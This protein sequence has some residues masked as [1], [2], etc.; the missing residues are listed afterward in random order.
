APPLLIINIKHNMLTKK[1]GHL[2]IDFLKQ[3]QQNN[4]ENVNIDLNLITAFLNT[5]SYEKIGYLHDFQFSP[6]CWETPERIFS[7]V[8]PDAITPAK[9]MSAIELSQWEQ[10]SDFA[11]IAQLTRSDNLY[12]QL[13]MLMLI[14]Q[15]YDLDFDLG[16]SG[17]H[18]VPCRVRDLLEEVC[19]DAPVFW[20]NTI[21]T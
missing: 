6:V 4:I 12:T 20:G 17:L 3:L 5:T 14:L 16:L 8:M 11:L 1:E 13:E 19:D 15:R 18:G 2:L 7:T 10:K 21:L 9:P